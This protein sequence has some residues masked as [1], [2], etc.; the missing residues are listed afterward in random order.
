MHGWTGTTTI[1][2]M[3][4][5]VDLAAPGHQIPDLLVVDTNLIIAHLMAHMHSPHP[6]TA[7]RAAYLFRAL[8][9]S[10]GI[11]L[12]TST[13]LN[14]VL[15]FAIKAKYRLEVQ[16]HLADLTAAYPNRSRFD[17]I[18]L[19][20]IDPGILQS[21]GPDLERL[22]QHLIGS[23]PLFLQPEDWSPVSAGDSRDSELVRVI[24]RYGLDSS[25]AA[26][27]LEARQAGIFTVAT[28]DPD[29]TRSAADFDVYTWL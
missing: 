10:N 12:V 3:G 5:V 20:K 9:A 19:Y 14:E 18:D 7:S 21:F 22:R 24:G 6:R 1:P 25:D 27:L 4:S 11:G 8:Q 23:N 16:S 15:H 13:S 29:L 26:L 2:R 28:L 17:W